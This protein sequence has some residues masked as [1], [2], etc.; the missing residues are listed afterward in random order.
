MS[1]DKSILTTIF[2]YCLLITT[3]LAEQRPVT[4]PLYQCPAYLQVGSLSYALQEQ[5][6]HAGV[7]ENRQALRS[8]P[9]P[10]EVGI[11][12]SFWLYETCPKLPFY[13]K[14]HYE[15]PGHSIVLEMQNVRRCTQTFTDV[16]SRIK[17]E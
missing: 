16:D 10:N 9:I 13:L 5:T 11:P 8:K 12:P 17:C 4:N 1:W 14:C 15:D 7:I 6:I 3:V 2:G